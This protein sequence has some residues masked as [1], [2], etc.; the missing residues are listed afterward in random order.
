MPSELNVGDVRTV[1]ERLEK[2]IDNSEFIPAVR[3]YRSI[4]LLGLI[5]KALT[6]AR[7]ICVLVEADFPGEAFGVSRTLIDIFLTIRYIG[8]KDTEARA[9]Q[10]A[11]FYAKDHEGW[12]KVIQKFYPAMTIPSGEFHEKSLEIAKE[13]KSAHQW[14]GLGDQTRQMAL[15]DDSY[16]FRSP[17]NPLNCEFDYEVIYKWTSFFVHGTVS[18]L[19][20]HLTE[21]AEAFRV[22]ARI[23]LEQGRGESALFNVLAYLSK[24]FVC[25]FRAMRQEQPEEILTDM[26][27]LMEL[28]AKSTRSKET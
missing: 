17:G 19:E 15:E 18:S 10:F 21:A 22:R 3:F 25:A 2:Y 13:Y 11:E 24:S 23:G 12:T 16:E 28:S 8:N 7:A 26:H 1:I 14:T 4:V 6:V 27:R 9:K 5:S 20:P